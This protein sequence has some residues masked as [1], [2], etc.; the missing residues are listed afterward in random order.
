MLLLLCPVAET[1]K[2]LILIIIIFCISCLNHESGLN[3]TIY[4]EIFN[5]RRTHNLYIHIEDLNLEIAI[6]NIIGKTGPIAISDVEGIT[7]LNLANKGISSLKGIEYLVN[8]EKLDISNN[9]ISDISPLETLV[10]GRLSELLV[11]GNPLTIGDLEKL[12]IWSG[13]SNDRDL[14]RHLLDWGFKLQSLEGDVPIYIN[15]I[16]CLKET[17]GYIVNIKIGGNII[18]NDTASTLVID[19][20][21]LEADNL[22]LLSGDKEVVIVTPEGLETRESLAEKAANRDIVEPEFFNSEQ[23]IAILQ[24]RTEQEIEHINQQ[25][26]EFVLEKMD[27]YIIINISDPIIYR[28][29]SGDRRTVEFNIRT[30]TGEIAIYFKPVEDE[31]EGR[32]TEKASEAGLAPASKYIATENQEYCVIEHFEGIKLMNILWSEPEILLKNYEWIFGELGNK[33]GI[34]DKEGI[35]YTDVIH[36]N[37]Y[38]NLETHE[39]AITDYEVAHSQAPVIQIRK[40]IEYLNK[41]IDITP[42]TQQEM[43]SIFNHAYEATVGGGDSSGSIEE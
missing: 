14:H 43:L 6:R 29:N 40:L 8:L 21:S 28:S 23:N 35:L 26:R 22:I 24:N 15:N 33:I 1:M 13:S 17:D 5:L 27:A 4:S 7:E 20:I 19:N 30:D 34:L 38:I 31:P 32:R 9:N 39:I 41:H 37:T 11:V 12:D 42:Q 3:H 18:L 25:I 2:N 10:R 16:Y 36:F